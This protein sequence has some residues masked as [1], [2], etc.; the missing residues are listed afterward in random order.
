MKGEIQMANFSLQIE[1]IDDNVYKSLKNNTLGNNSWINKCLNVLL[2]MDNSIIAFDADWGNGKTFLAKQFQMIINEKWDMLFNQRS[3]SE[4]NNIKELN[5]KD[6]IDDSYYAIYYNAWEYD[7]E[8]DPIASF[9]YYLLKILNKKI[10][11]NTFKSI[12]SNFVKNVIEKISFGWI[13]ISEEGEENTIEKVLS[14]V[15]ET[16]TIRKEIKKLLNELRKEKFDK[17]IIFIDELDRCRPTYALKIIEMIKHYLKMENILIVCMTDIKQLSNCIKKVYGNDY[18][19]NMYLDK[20]FD[21]KFNLPC[22]KYDFKSY[23]NMKLN[24]Y[25]QDNYF[26][27]MICM[28]V[29]NYFNLSLR[30][31]DKY[32]SYI[33][34]MFEITKKGGDNDFTSRAFVIYLFVPYYVATLLFKQ[35]LYDNFMKGD[36]SEYIQ[37]CKRD[38]VLHRVKQIYSLSL[39][40]DYD[41][42][43]LFDYF[44]QDCKLM[45]KQIKGEKS[46]EEEYIVDKGYF[47]YKVNSYLKNIDLLNFFII[48]TKENN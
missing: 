2:K 45:I 46:Q 9:L 33:G 11:T 31:V 28:E 32:L 20:I 36:L 37:F 42:S 10:Q 1:P 16:E 29:I 48:N 38:N 4:F 25:V 39:K 30:N 3:E 19:S 13:K 17:L 12:S 43:K 27:D 18:N 15:I 5:F 24:T 7:N 6:I 40:E 41:E 23:V 14:S 47:M 35:E 21:Y 34:K 26:F 22:T 44:T 8:N